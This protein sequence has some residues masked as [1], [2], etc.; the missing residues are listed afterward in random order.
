MFDIQEEDPRAVAARQMQSKQAEAVEVAKA[1]R[2]KALAS[3]EYGGAASIISGV[4]NALG[5]IP[6]AGPVINAVMQLASAG[7]RA[8]GQYAEKPSDKSGKTAAGLSTAGAVLGGVG[9]LVGAATDA[10]GSG[11]PDAP[12]P[13]LGATPIQTQDVFGGQDRTGLTPRSPMAP[14]D[15]TP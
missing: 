12:D 9:N 6:V 11:A 14:Y 15:P 5:S 8:G 4:G 3:A 2:D 10:A 7:V 13:T 1:K